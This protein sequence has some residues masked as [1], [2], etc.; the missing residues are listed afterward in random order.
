MF[1]YKSL[2]KEYDTIWKVQVRE[3]IIQLGEMVL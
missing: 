3:N 2:Q 1:M